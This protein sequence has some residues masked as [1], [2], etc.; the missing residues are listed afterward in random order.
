EPPSHHHRRHRPAT[1]GGPAWGQQRVG[2]DSPPEPRSSSQRQKQMEDGKTS[3]HGKT[4]DPCPSEWLGYKRKCY[5]IS[6]EEENWTSCQIFCAKNQ[7]LLA[8][9]DGWEEMHSFIKHLKRDK[10]WIGLRKKGENFYWE[11]GVRLEVNLFQVHNHS[12][13]AY[14]V[15]STIY[16]SSCSM[17]RRCI[18]I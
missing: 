17:P 18:C 6:E 2:E 7:S 14:L 11:N 9:F 15:D 8:V 12:E 4:P 10:Y 1:T 16:T 3:H 13:Y 5:F